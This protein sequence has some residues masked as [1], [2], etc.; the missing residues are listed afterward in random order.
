MLIAPGPVNLDKQMCQNNHG[1][2]QKRVAIINKYRISNFKDIL[3]VYQWGCNSSE[4]CV[5]EKHYVSTANKRIKFFN[6]QE[7][8]FRNQKKP[9]GNRKKSIYRNRPLKHVS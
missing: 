7:K 4:R 9:S 8:D 2:S 5:L 6:L 1:V 3:L